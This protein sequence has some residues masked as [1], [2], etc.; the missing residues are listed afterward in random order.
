[1]RLKFVLLAALMGCL[2][3]LV[4][5]PPGHSQFPGGPG[6]QPPAGNLPGANPAERER[7]AQAPPADPAAPPVP[8][9]WIDEWFHRLDKD[10]D[11]YLSYEEMTETLQAEKDIWDRNKDGKIDIDEWREYIEAFTVHQR[12]LAAEEEAARRGGTKGPRRGPRVTG[13]W[14]GNQGKSI[15][16]ALKERDLARSSADENLQGTGSPDARPESNLPPQF[17]HYDT[18]GDGQIALHEWRARNGTLEDFQ[19]YDLD[20]D[21]FITVEE[22]LRVSRRAARP[23][24]L[25]QTYR[26]Y[27]RDGDG[28]IALHEWKDKGGNVADFLKYDLDSDGFLSLEE[29]IQA[30]LVVRPPPNPTALLSRSEQDHLSNLA[31]KRTYGYI[32]TQLLRDQLRRLRALNLIRMVGNHTVEGLYDDRR[33]NLSEFVQLT[34]YGSRY[35]FRGL[36]NQPPP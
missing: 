16:Q 29:L 14:R 3:L 11:G 27:D 35:L 28:L 30:G 26:H 18:N 21:G 19:K 9:P 6:G 13:P 31:L 22:L 17:R 36:E 7:N 15:L 12:R 25:P 23:N 33:F 5:S 20:D 2:A 32:G 24:N 8:N 1:M 34:D 4:G 10:G